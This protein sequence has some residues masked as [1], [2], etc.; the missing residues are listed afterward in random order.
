MSTEALFEQVEL[1][2]NEIDKVCDPEALR[3]MQEHT[4][5][6]HMDL[7]DPADYNTLLGKLNSLEE[8]KGICMNRLYYLSIPPTAY[9][10]VIHLLGEQGL[11]SSCQH[12]QAMTR[13]LVGKPFG[14]TFAPQKH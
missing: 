12:G 5:M 7:H 9:L 10:A 14:L 8:Q 6:F 2:V 13:L 3:S 1:C 11:N 4:T